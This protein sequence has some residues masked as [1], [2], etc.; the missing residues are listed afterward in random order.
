[1]FPCTQ[2]EGFVRRCEE[3]STQK[4]GLA[5]RPEGESHCIATLRLSKDRAFCV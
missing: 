5:R 1:M 4:E 3:K 2:M